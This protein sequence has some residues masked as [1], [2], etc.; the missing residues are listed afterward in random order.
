MRFSL[1]NGFCLPDP[2]MHCQSRQ[3]H[4]LGLHT[5]PRK[6][7]LDAGGTKFFCRP[8]GLQS[9][10]ALTHMFTK[11]ESHSEEKAFS[12]WMSTFLP[13]YWFIAW[14]NDH[15]FE[16]LASILC[17][18]SSLFME[19]NIAF[20]F[21]PWSISNGDLGLGKTSQALRANQWY[22]LSCESGSEDM[23]CGP[24]FAVDPCGFPLLLF[25]GQSLLFFLHCKCHV[26]SATSNSVDVVFLTFFVSSCWDKKQWMRQNWQVGKQSYHP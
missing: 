17:T 24:L 3:R 2:S 13:A 11:M 15:S 14:M 1:N 4:L 22:R 10:S 12:R 23:F 25:L 16:P 19:C 8:N 7:K 18:M 5:T 21:F 20:L 26:S 9:V 6:K